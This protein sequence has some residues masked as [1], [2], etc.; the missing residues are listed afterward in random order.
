[1]EPLERYLRLRRYVDVLYD[2]QDVRMRTENRFRQMPGTAEIYVKPLLKIEADLTQQI[3]GMLQTEPIY[4]QFF[5]Q[6]RGVGPRISGFIISQTMIKFE[7]V[8]K[9]EFKRAR[10]LLDDPESTEPAPFTTM[11]IQLSQK[12]KAGAYRVPHLR[13][14]GKFDNPSRYHS[15]W[16]LGIDPETGRSPR[17][18]RGERLG[19]SP[20][21][22]SFSWR[23]KRSFKMQKAHKSFYR[24]IY[25]RYKKRLF[26][27]PRE[28]KAFG[29]KAWSPPFSEILKNPEACPHYKPCKA[30]LKKRKEPACRGHW[31]NM[32]MKYACKIFLTHTWEQ[33]RMI[34]G[35]PVRQPYAL[36]KLGHTTYIEWEPDKE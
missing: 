13:G 36:A 30:S 8:S 5:R 20:K 21:L 7:E 16:G 4:D 33:W 11:Q 1:M 35:L 12:T 15:W 14:I 22:R 24:R 18:V 27:K 23:I 3:D 10:D 34:E 32:A 2:M 6:V 29:R 25:D 28:S 26:E 9:E 17:R 19:Y 31:D